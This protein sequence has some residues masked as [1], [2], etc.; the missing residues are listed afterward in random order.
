MNH[1][2]LLPESLANQIA[3]GEVVQ[4]PS[5]VVKELLENA[6]D[7]GSTNIQLIVKEAG[8][9]LI[10]VVDN[11]TGMSETDARMCFERHATSKISKTE[12]LFAIH[13]FGFRGEAMASIAA[14]AQVLLKAKRKTDETGTTIQIEGSKVKL[15]KPTAM[16]DGT[17]VSVKNLFFNVPARRNFLKS[18]A[19]EL[20]HILDEFQRVALSNPQINMA[21]YQDGK[22]IYVL[23][24]GKLAKRITS[25]F[26]KN[27]QGQII[28]CSEEVPQVKIQGYIGKPESA[29]KLGGSNFFL[30]II[31]S[32][33]TLTCIMQ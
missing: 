33:S 22:E 20:K 23:K 19:V 30:S 3:A 21:F 25:L 2:R 9:I 1:I 17:N 14:V 27:Y 8:K 12:D 13:T 10:Q 16:S 6:V 32:S 24:F 15:Q 31:A 18:N 4:R 26:G 5:S 11:G 7:A 28:K 29:K